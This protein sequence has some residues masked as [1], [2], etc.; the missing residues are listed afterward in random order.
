[1]RFNQ[2]SVKVMGPLGDD[3][4]WLFTLNEIFSNY[5][6]ILCLID[7]SIWRLLKYFSGQ[8]QFR[9]LV[10]TFLMLG[11]FRKFILLLYKEKNIQDVISVK[12]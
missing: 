4:T 11:V 6:L 9:Y 8:F 3:G 12:K 5:S 1:M 10:C 7:H 2:W